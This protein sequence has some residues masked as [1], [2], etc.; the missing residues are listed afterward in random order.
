MIE[1]LDKLKKLSFNYATQS[2]ISIS[3]FE[4]EE[5]IDK[6]ILLKKTEEKIKEID[7]HYSQGFYNEEE[8]KQTKINIWQ[9]CKDQLQEKLISNLEKKNYTSL[10]Y[11][12]DSGAR[13]SSENLTQIF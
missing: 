5:I 1:F 9:G 4:I 13:I 8:Y 10:Y 2:G 7:Q 11:I 6:K 12:R 3:P